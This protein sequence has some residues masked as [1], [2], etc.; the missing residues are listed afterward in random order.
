MGN[1]MEI[2]LLGNTASPLHVLNSVPTVLTCGEK[3]REVI[4]NGNKVSEKKF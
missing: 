3:G 2:Q 1:T 4:T